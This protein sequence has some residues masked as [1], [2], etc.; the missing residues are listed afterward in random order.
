MQMSKHT[1]ETFSTAFFK[2]S[3]NKAKKKTNLKL[4]LQIFAYARKCIS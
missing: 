4:N 3:R 2:N 1:K